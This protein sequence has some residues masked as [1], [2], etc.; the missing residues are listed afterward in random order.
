[1]GR[2]EQKWLH[3]CIGKVKREERSGSGEF[4]GR[5]LCPR[6]FRFTNLLFFSLTFSTPPSLSVRRQTTT[7]CSDVDALIYA[8]G[9]SFGHLAQIPALG[10]VP[11]LRRPHSE[12][13]AA[14]A[15][16]SFDSTIPIL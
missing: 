8:D 1:M 5:P 2:G 7:H 16:E 11:R 4:S 9:S 13:I 3:R 6:F 14:T 12:S 10:G 15:S